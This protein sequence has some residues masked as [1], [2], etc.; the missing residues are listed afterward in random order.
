[1]ESLVHCPCGHGIERHGNTG[2]AGSTRERCNCRLKSTAALDAA[3]ERVRSSG[4]AGPFQR[5][6]MSRRPDDLSERAD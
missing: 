6:E 2:C 4:A 5:W 3:V 1:M